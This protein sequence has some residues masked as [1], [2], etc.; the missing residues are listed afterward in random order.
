MQL[1]SLLTLASL[2]TTKFYGY[3]DATFPKVHDGLRA[4]VVKILQEPFD[5]IIGK[6]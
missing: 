6:S 2:Y 3:H 1:P 4:N 5:F